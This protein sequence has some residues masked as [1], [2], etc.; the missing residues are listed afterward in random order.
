MAHHDKDS[1]RQILERGDLE[2]MYHAELEAIHI[3]NAKQL[4]EIIAAHGLPGKSLVDEDG[5]EATWLIVQHAISLPDFQR[6]CLPLFQDACAKGEFPAAYVAYLEDRI[7]FFEARPQR[8]GTHYDWNDE[9]QLV[10]YIIEDVDTVDALRASVG[11]SSVEE[12]TSQMR[13]NSAKPP[14]DYAVKRSAYEAW[15]TKVG[16]RPKVS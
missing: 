10:P 8:Y 14:K 4:E 6:K 11:L 5:A 13:S 2:D 12:N 16:W 15:L 9:G 1:A 3:A 7:R